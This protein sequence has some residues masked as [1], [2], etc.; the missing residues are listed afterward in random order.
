MK[1]SMS[2]TLGAL[3]LMAGVLAAGCSSSPSAE[4]LKQLEDLKAEVASMET[5]LQSLESEKAGLQKT[6]A[7]RDA[8]L[9]KCAEDKAVAEQRLKGM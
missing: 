2:L 6:V 1:K 9:K 4:E 5:Q 8:Q 7:D 3:F